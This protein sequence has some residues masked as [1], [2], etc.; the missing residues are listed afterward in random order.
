MAPNIIHNHMYSVARQ[1]KFQSLISFD[2]GDCGGHKVVRVG[3][4]TTENIIQC[5]Y[6][7]M[8]KRYLAYNIE[9]AT[10]NRHCVTDHSA[11]LGE[12]LPLDHLSD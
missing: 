11:H 10:T 9:V 8:G 3:R 1:P 4:P 7:T 6:T 2:A 5:I 12:V